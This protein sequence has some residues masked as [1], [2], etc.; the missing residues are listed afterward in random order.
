[1]SIQDNLFHAIEQN[2]VTGVRVILENDP[3]LKAKI[4]GDHY[5]FPPEITPMILAAYENKYDILK[6]LYQFGHRLKV[7]QQKLNE[8]FSCNNAFV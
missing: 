5:Y 4:V 1:M 8:V 7:S 3:C 2:Y 6:L